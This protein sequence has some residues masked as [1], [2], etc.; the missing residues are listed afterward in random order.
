MNQKN[1]R[2]AGIRNAAILGF[3]AASCAACA[4]GESGGGTALNINATAS[5]EAIPSATSTPFLPPADT[6]APSASTATPAV[7][8]KTLS[9]S[10][11]LPS[12]FRSSLALP[13]D[14]T[15]VDDPEAADI[16]LQLGNDNPVSTWIYAL[17]APFL[18][19]PDGLAAA[20][21]Q[22]AWAGQ[23]G[24]LFSGAP[25]LMDQNTVDVFSTLWGY[26]APGSVAPVPADR[27]LDTAWSNFTAWAIVPWEEIQPRWKVLELDGQ[28]PM[29]KEFDPAA[30]LLAAPISCIG[31]AEL[32][33]QAAA[34]FLP[35]TNRDP[36]K[37]TTLILTGV[38]ALVRATAYTME[39][40]GILY[41][42]QD[43]G[44]LLQSADL[45]HISNEIP[46]ATNCPPPDPSPGMTPFCSDPR[47]IDLLD[48]I[49]TDVVEMT[50]NHVR[51]YGD[52]ALRYTLDLYSKRG[53]SYY[54]SGENLESARKPIR[55]ENNGNRLAFIGCNRPGYNGEW[56]T[57]NTPGAAPCDFEY[58]QTEIR[59]LRSD[60]YLPV[61][62]FQYYEYYHF[63]PTLQQTR[64]FRL[65]AEAGA[66]IVSGSQ[67]H[68]P[69]AFDFATD[70]L[71]HYGLGNLFFDQFG[72]GEGTEEAF[73]DRHV[74]Y[75]GRYLGAEL[76]TIRF[77]DF[78]RPRFMTAGERA[79]LLAAAF[80]AS[81]W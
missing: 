17:V 21:L 23:G 52:D 44:S 73:I 71:I 16:Q 36:S 42:A 54:A 26:P 76:I 60:G 10:P 47:Y 80:A 20:D 43:I 64:E 50:G 78:A 11:V 70:A 65:V 30:Y 55:M 59:Q 40:R 19:V 2:P 3:L 72:F 32:C 51:D 6:P 48:Y 33:A 69:Q 7:E 1:N 35:A 68:H 5:L 67:A 34:S 79:D 58:L 45:T 29:R 38:T 63:E 27:L 28:S 8:E 46:F 31:E 25:L 22:R 61:V 13:Q 74:F 12:T 53:W 9:M 39:N 62:T 66:A 49:G 4:L 77:V 41:P 81:V 75:A 24:G 18:T 57:E 37:L 14:W 15:A 56:A